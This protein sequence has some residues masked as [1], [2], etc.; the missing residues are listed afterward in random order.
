MTSGDWH[1]W[2]SAYDDP[3]SWQAKRLITVRERIGIALDTAPPGPVTVLAL[4]AGEGRDLLPVLA[5]HPRRNEVTALLVELD[6]RN[7]EV[8]RTTARDLDLPGVQVITG[9]AALTDHYLGA[10]PADLVL[11]CGLFPHITDD[12][13]ATVVEHTASFTKRGGTV[14]WTRHRREPDLVP[15]ISA[16]FTAR[17]FAQVWISDPSVEFAVGVHRHL[18]DPPP[19]AAGVRLFTFVGVQALRPWEVPAP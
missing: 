10:A 5:E 8:A 11:I 16:W 12:D 18:A 2:H 4:A 7:A 19:V 14:V 3:D 9:D 1:A 17:S 6:P 13:I 15:Q